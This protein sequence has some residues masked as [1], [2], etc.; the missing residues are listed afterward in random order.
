VVALGYFAYRRAIVRAGLVLLF[1]ASVVLIGFTRSATGVVVLGALL[2]LMAAFLVWNRLSGRLHRVH[3]AIVAAILVVL[4]V[5]LVAGRNRLFALI[6]RSSSLTGRVPLWGYII[7]LTA[8][9]N[10]WLG[11]G[12]WTV[13]RFLDFRLRAEAAL[14]W[15][16]QV[17]NGHNGFVDV[18]TYL[19]VVGLALFGALTVQTLWRTASYAVKARTTSAIWIVLTS[20]YVVL[21]NLTISFFFQFETFHWVLLVIVLFA[22]TPLPAEASAAEPHAAVPSDGTKLL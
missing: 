2:G 9:H 6:G 16:F 13:W 19:G 18:F 1:V 20:V 17:I 14:R 10:I 5:V 22:G 8:K 21:A 7:D 15:S 12:L 3:Y 4:G 11:Y